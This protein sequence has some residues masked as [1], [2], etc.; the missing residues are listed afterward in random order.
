[1]CWLVLRCLKCSALLLG[2]PFGKPWTCP[3]PISV[4]KTAKWLRVRSKTFLSDI[5]GAFQPM[6]SL[7]ILML[8]RVCTPRRATLV[9]NTS[10]C[11]SMLGTSMV[12]L[13]LPYDEKDW[14]N[15]IEQL[16]PTCKSSIHITSFLFLAARYLPCL[17]ANGR[18]EWDRIEEPLLESIQKTTIPP[19]KKKQPTF[20]KM[21][22]QTNISS[23]LLISFWN[24]SLVIIPGSDQ[25]HLKSLENV[26]PPGRFEANNMWNSWSKSKA[27]FTWKNG[28]K[29]SRKH[30]IWRFGP[31]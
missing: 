8:P 30:V 10:S 29:S 27:E 7:S 24:H 4:W 28:G 6:I 25:T 9:P 18:K 19:Q 1:M 3:S 21:W 16:N 12:N 26:H 31:V 20:V 5:L 13:I 22:G 17:I 11:D 2:S 15:N 23:S 14:Q